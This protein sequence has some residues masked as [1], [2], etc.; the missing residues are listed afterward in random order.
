[1]K[2]SKNCVDYCCLTEKKMN[3]QRLTN[4]GS[5]KNMKKTTLS[6]PLVGNLSDRRMILAPVLLGESA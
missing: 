3:S 2:N 5:S 4:R 1:M 6:F